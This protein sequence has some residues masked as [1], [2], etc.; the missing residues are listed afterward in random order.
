MSYTI[1]AKVTKIVDLSSDSIKMQIQGIGQYQIEVS[2]MQKKNLLIEE[3]NST[4]ILLD[5]SVG[6]KILN[7]ALVQNLISGAMLQRIPLKFM[8]DGSVKA[9]YTITSCEMI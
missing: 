6:I 3:S 9:K 1:N 8:I 7:N 2:S 4:A 5:E